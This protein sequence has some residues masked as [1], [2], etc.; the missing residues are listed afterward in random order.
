MEV[1]DRVKSAANTRNLGERR[2]PDKGGESTRNSEKKAERQRPSR[3]SGSHVAKLAEHLTER[4]RQI[5]LDCYEHHVL[6]TDQIRGLHFTGGRTARARLQLL[7]ELRVLDHFRPR[8]GLGEGSRPYHWVLDEAG[9]LIVA[10]YE[11]IDRS[12]LRYTHDDGMQIA[13]SRNLDHHVEANEFFSR[14]A[15]EANAAGGELREWY[16]VRTLAHM[17]SGAIVPDGYGVLAMPGTKPLHVLLELDRSTE[18]GGVLR[19]KAK[20]YAEMLPHS[21]L[22][23]LD[24]FVILATPSARRAQ[25]ASAAVSS[26]SAPLSVAVWNR[27]TRRS[28]LATVARC[29]FDARRVPPLTRR[30]DQ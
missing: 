18:A 15:V 13:M 10:D 12:E 1:A 7:Y 19:D 8:P 29:A 14:L 23:M 22:A 16:G 4:D 2:H 11:G 9:A 26:T 25:T 28:V 21:S 27:K 24:P 3:I 20:R 6:T 30:A 5:A 17:F